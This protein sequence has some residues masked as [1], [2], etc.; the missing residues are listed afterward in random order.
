PLVDSPDHGDL[1]SGLGFSPSP[2]VAEFSRMFADVPEVPF[3]PPRIF[4]EI[5]SLFKFLGHS[6][7]LYCAGKGY[8]PLPLSPLLSLF[9]FLGHSLCL[10]CAGGHFS[11]VI[12]FGFRR[13]LVS[14]LIRLWRT[15]LHHP[16]LWQTSRLLP[17]SS[18]DLLSYRL[19]LLRPLRPLRY[20]PM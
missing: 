18:R 5:S 3:V 8:L 11:F 17:T 14:L 19:R 9:K 10:Y 16:H 2:V 6:L 7:C 15:R 4:S 1:E 13:H 20:S 12:G